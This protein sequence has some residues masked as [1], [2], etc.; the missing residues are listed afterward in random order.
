MNSRSILL[1]IF[2][3]TFSFCYSQSENPPR[4]YAD[5]TIGGGSYRGTLSVAA[6]HDWQLGNTKKFTF[7]LGVRF[8]GFLGANLYYI[9][10]PAKLTSGSTGPLVLFKENI[11]DNIDSL[12]VKSPQVNSLNAAVNLGYSLS[13]KISIGFN[14]DAIGF[15][16]GKTTRGNYINGVEGKN[17]EGKPTPFNILLVSDNDRGS[18]NSELYVKYYL[19]DQWSLKLAGQFLFTE[20]TTKTKVQQFPEENDRFRNKSL[21]LGIGVTCKL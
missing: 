15:S 19:N 7:G 17:T 21:L 20:Y 14:I 5:L 4:N 6:F 13:K 8:T 11:I 10:A 1:I 12:L 18:L 9:T 16:F 2:L 3:F